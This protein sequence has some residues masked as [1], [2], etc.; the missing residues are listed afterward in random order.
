ME[1]AGDLRR[2]G[3]EEFRRGQ[4]G[5]AAELYSRALAVLEDAGTAGPGGAG[6][7][8]PH[9][10]APHLTAVCRAG[11]AA[12]EERSVLLANRAACQLRDGACRGCVADCC[13]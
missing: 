10:T 12:A 2:A 7:G 11:E 4:Y 1:S 5:A 9:R 6:P 13:R 8:S 3:N